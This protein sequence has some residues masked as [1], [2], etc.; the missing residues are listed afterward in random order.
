MNKTI[1][2]LAALLLSLFSACTADL[3][4]DNT[5]MVCPS[6]FSATLIEQ[7]K[8]KPKQ[9]PAAEVTQYTYKGN[10]VYLVTGGC[11]DNYN[12]LFDRCGNVLCAAS[13]GLSGTGDGR[14]ADFTAKATDPVLLWRDPR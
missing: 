7:L 12:Y 6:D 14:C 2:L 8:Q 1:T 9:T 3:S 11:C 5:N 4:G 10:T 13:G